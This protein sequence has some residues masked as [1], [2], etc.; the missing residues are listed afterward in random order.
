MNDVTYNAGWINDT[1]KLSD[2]LT[3]NLGLRFE[4]YK[5]GWGEQ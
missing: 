1:W 3:L 4:T 5:D 2:R